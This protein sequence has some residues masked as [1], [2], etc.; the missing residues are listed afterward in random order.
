MKRK[1]RERLSQLVKLA[2]NPALSK[3]ERVRLKQ[4]LHPSKAVRPILIPKFPSIIGEERIYQAVD[5]VLS[6]SQDE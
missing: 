1:P 4:R 2:H 6:E 5:S 3:R